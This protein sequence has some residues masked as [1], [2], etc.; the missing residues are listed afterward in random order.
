[1]NRSYVKLGLAL[2]LALPAA[3]LADSGFYIGA[4]VGG[5]T[6]DANLGNIPGLPN[7]I[8]EDD[9]AFKGFV[10]YRLDLPSTF[11]GI[12]GGYVDL[13]EAE[14]T[15]L[16]QSV[17]VDTSGVNL[18]GMAGLE[19]GPLEFFV[20]AG[21]IAWDIDYS[22]LGETGSEDGSD[23]GYGVG[24]QFSVGPVYVRGEYEQYDA[25][26]ADLSM[27]SVGISFLFD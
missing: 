4:S 5:A 14:L 13:G 21:Y 25:D 16:D 1:M 22:A 23:L 24:M 26:D 2:W 19:A 20:K 10:G 27:V 15:V 11:L 17:S 8:D 9:T 12:E 3:A 7:D 6:L 18:W